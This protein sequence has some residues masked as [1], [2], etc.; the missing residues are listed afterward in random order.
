MRTL[1]LFLILVVGC[2]A[3]HGILDP[4]P[5]PAAPTP[6]GCSVTWTAPERP[7][8]NGRVLPLRFAL[9]PPV[10]EAAVEVH[11][12]GDVTLVA[13]VPASGGLAAD[14][15]A[16]TDGDYT[17][18]VACAGGCRTWTIDNVPPP[19]VTGLRRVDGPRKNQSVHRGRAHSSDSSGSLRT[20]GD[21][22]RPARR[23]HGAASPRAGA[24]RG[25][26]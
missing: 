3:R 9:T 25:T 16:P 15:P 14:V 5:V 10:D 11:F 21:A 6:A 2:D 4:G 12:E 26:P 23:P 19:P 18:C 13:A 1:F 8:I 7:A 24:R 22:P 20:R 17:V